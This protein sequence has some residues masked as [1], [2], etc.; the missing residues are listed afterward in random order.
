M[1]DQRLGPSAGC[2]IVALLTPALWAMIVG[3]WYLLALM[4]RGWQ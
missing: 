2:L 1:K 3:T 4:M